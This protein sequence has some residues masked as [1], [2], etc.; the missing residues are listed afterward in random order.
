MRYQVVVSYDGTD[1]AGFQSQSNAV[2]IQDIIEKGFRLMTQQEIRIHGAGRTDKGVHAMGQVFHFDSD[3]DITPETWVKG[4]NARLP[5]AIR[6]KTVKPVHARF[7]ARHDAKMKVY[8]YVIAKTEGT[9]FQNRY[10]AY[11]K[12]I[13]SIRVRAFLPVFEGTHDF[14]GFCKYVK[15]KDTTRT[16]ESITLKETK[17]HLVI[18]FRG[19]SFLRY[20]VRSIMGTVIAVGT[21]QADPKIAK[22]ILM[23]KDRQQAPMTAPA[24]GL[25]L[26]RIIY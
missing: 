15:G 6:I 20:M 7:H 12:D 16:I 19:K 22:E 13:D 9:P 8:R 14:K 26:V 11:V 5:I 3:L 25:F 23:T 17:R 1:Y 24:S 4:V 21:H 2:G 10:E 18:T